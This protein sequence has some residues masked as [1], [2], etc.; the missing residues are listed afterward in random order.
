MIGSQ[1]YGG[2]LDFHISGVRPQGKPLR[3][4]HRAS[5]ITFLPIDRIKPLKDIFD[6]EVYVGD[7]VI[8]HSTASIKL[9]EVTK[10]NPKTN[11]ISVKPRSKNGEPTYGWHTEYSRNKLLLVRDL[12]LVSA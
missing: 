8:I 6:R 12:D 11:R 10:Y 3:A 2:T 1:S 5:E 7:L 9:V 4:T